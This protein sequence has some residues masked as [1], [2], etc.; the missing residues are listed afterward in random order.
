MDDLVNIGSVDSSLDLDRNRSLRS[1]TTDDSIGT[2]NC[3]SILSDL[4]S[5]D[6][7]QDPKNFGFKLHSNIYTYVFIYRHRK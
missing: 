4:E 6:V 7:A 1:R 3:D 5:W 2:A